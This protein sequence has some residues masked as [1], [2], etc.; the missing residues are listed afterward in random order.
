LVANSNPCEKSASPSKTE[1]STPH[2]ALHV[3]RD[4]RNSA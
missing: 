1:S 3:A 4:L 2:F